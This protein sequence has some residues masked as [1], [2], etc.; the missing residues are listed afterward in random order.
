MSEPASD[1]TAFTPISAE[2]AAAYIFEVS[3]ELAALAGERGLTRLAAALELSRA[4]AAEALAS[5]A[6]AAQSLPK[7]AAP[8]DAA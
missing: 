5:M 6:V 8:G 2:D 7:K 3:S 4:Q 1:E